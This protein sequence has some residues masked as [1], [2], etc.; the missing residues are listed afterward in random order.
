M[1]DTLNALIT[2]LIPVENKNDYAWK[3]M[4]GLQ[5]FRLMDDYV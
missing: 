1:S 3:G 2:R 4:Y 5:G